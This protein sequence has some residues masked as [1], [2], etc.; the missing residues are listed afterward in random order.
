VKPPKEFLDFA[1]EM[2][3]PQAV[4]LIEMWEKM[5]RG[6]QN[7]VCGEISGYDKHH[8][9]GEEPCRSCKDAKAEQSKEWYRANPEKKRA[10]GIKWDQ[11]HPGYHAAKKRELRKKW[12]QRP[13]PADK[14][15]LKGFDYYQ[16]R[17]DV[18]RTARREFNREYMR[19]Y[20]ARRKAMVT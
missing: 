4:T 20:R 6:L 19:T 15:G 1:V 16:C 7:P 5:R 17:C 9:E 8:Y 2:C 13:C 11:A 14:H 3:G 10:A 18:C 12:A